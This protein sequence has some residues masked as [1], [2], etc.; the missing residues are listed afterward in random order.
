MTTTPPIICT[1]DA[2]L[3]NAT[4]PPISP[5]DIHEKMIA[6]YAGTPAALWWSIGDHEIYN[7]ETQIGQLAGPES[8][9][10]A[11]NLQHLID[12]CGG[13]LT[14]LFDLCR[15][16]HLQCFPRVRMNS[17]Y[18]VDPSAP[19]FGTLRQQH[20]GYLIGRPGNQYPPGSTE[21]G[22]RTGLDFALPQVRAYKISIIAEL[23]DRFD[24][25][26]LELD[27]MRHPAFFHPA[28][29]YQHRHYMTDL[30]HQVRA[31]LNQ[32]AAQRHHTIQLAVRVP[33]TLYDCARIGLDVAHWMANDL[34]DIVTAGGGFI[35]YETPIAEFVAAGR[36]RIP[37]YGCIE[38]TRYADE[39]NLRAI[40]AHFWSTGASGI[41]LYNFFTMP[42]EWNRRVLNQLADPAALEHLDKRYELDQTARF[43]TPY[44]CAYPVDN[45]EATFRYAS[46]PAQLPITLETTV[47]SPV[48]LYL[49]I[50]DAPNADALDHCTLSLRFDK[51]NPDAQ[52]NLTFNDHPL[53]WPSH[54][55]SPNGWPRQEIAAEFWTHYPTQIVEVQQEGT[56]IEF[57]LPPTS[58]KQE[59]NTI[60][61]RI[62]SKNKEN[63]S[64]LLKG[65]ELLLTYTPKKT[66]TPPPRSP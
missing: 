1:D 6:P 62:V 63:V 54:R 55:L 29:A 17:H 41:Y 46:P 40:A 14:T 31:H 65:L 49:K 66:I 36:D 12:T 4:Q 37:V 43:T 32:A 24:L 10:V 34:V 3:L 21:Y 15:N 38:S 22:L 20:P 48:L 44:H 13:P 35:P 26:G 50:A 16:A 39:K 5:S 51:F 45:I 47:E 7:Y 33:P 64:I 27:F 30:I 25:D 11:A 61:I 18:D 9:T 60:K 2:W 19:A 28:Q 58:L 53:P 56:S 59:E 42:P 57:D 8:P 23:L 52:L